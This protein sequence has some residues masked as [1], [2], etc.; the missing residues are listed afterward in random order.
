MS[1][2]ANGLP[3]KDWCTTEGAAELAERIR[4]YWAIRGRTVDVRTASMRDLGDLYLQG[5]MCLRSN[6][7][8]GLPPID[9]EAPV[10]FHPSR[11]EPVVNHHPLVRA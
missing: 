3:S 6:M 1:H 7:V 10:T 5:V 9:K 4:S 8:G 2:N 11:P